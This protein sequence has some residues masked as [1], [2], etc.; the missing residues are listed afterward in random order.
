MFSES[1]KDVDFNQFNTSIDS[2]KKFTDVAQY[3]KDI[4]VSKIND[5]GA[6]LLDLGGTGVDDFIKA[7][8]DAYERAKATGGEF[9]TKIVEGIES[10]KEDAKN[11]VNNV[12]QYL[13]DAVD[14]YKDRFK[15]AGNNISVYLANGISDKSVLTDRAVGVIASNAINKIGTYYNRFRQAGRN[16]IIG[17]SN[18]M[19]D[20]NGL[21]MKNASIIANNALYAMKKRLDE[22]SPSKETYKYGKWFVEGFNEGMEDQTN[23]STQIADSLSSNVLKN[24]SDGM[25]AATANLNLN[26]EVVPVMN[27]DKAIDAICEPGGPF[28]ALEELYGEC[29][30]IF[31][32][33]IVPVMK[34][35]GV[36]STSDY[37]FSSGFD[38]SDY[39]NFEYL[40]G[41][42]SGNP[43]PFYDSSGAAYPMESQYDQ[44][45]RIG[46]SN[47]LP[48]QPFEEVNGQPFE[49]V[50][51]PFETVNNYFTINEASD[52]V[53]T[54]NEVSN[55]IGQTM[56]R[57]NK[58]WE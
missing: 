11:R 16:M 8:T 58:A 9:L 38:G 32:P 37:A 55:R 52:P 41:S 50:G 5:L 23:E 25:D 17:F 49:E 4:E 14:G 18:G 12:V 15:T 26:P 31:R 30:K 46:S 54:A 57:R 36:S 33:E 2:I 3:V 21:V 51:Q 42:S 39:G 43:Q 53:R 29:D 20:E 1:V 27:A 10:K 7:F 28:D 45:A 56:K 24:F 6:A 48:G 35:D 44:A 40:G 47:D 13:L 19:G 22:H 34:M